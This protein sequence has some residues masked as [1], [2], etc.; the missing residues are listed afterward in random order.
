MRPLECDIGILQKS[1]GSVVFQQ[2]HTK[3]TTGV[4]GPAEVQVHK[5]HVD[6]TTL[7]CVLKPKIGLAGVREKNMEDIVRKTCEQAILLKLFPRSAVQIVIQL[8][9]DSGG[10]LSCLIN[11]ACMA[12]VH[13]GI[14]MRCMIASVCCVVMDD[15]DGG[16]GGVVVVDPTTEEESC[17]RCTMTL[18]F[19]SKQMKLVSSHTTGTFTMEEYFN[20]IQLARQSAAEVF[21]FQRLSV[22]RFLSRD[23]EGGDDDDDDDMV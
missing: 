13:A 5:E 9:H 4:F 10:L 6:R 3:V 22:S 17:A 16:G 19:E 1:D 18:S 2:G 15:D 23:Q 8:M 11:S 20:C 14:P 21:A 12:L 7:S